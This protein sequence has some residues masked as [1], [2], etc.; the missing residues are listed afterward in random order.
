[1]EVEDN[2][3]SLPIESNWCII[4]IWYDALKLVARVQPTKGLEGPILD[5]FIFIK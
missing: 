4:G 5:P 2:D 3:G 1:M